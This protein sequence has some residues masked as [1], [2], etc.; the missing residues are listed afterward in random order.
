MLVTRPTEGDDL[1]RIVA[2]AVSGGVDLVQLRDKEAS[3]ESVM[4]LAARLREV[5]GRR[6]VLLVNHPEWRKML[7]VVDGVHLPE[8][9]SGALP[10]PSL[11]DTR[12]PT[13]DT[14]LFGRS[15]H[16][17]EAAT[18]AVEEGADYVVA[19]AIFATKSHP[20]MPP[21]G[22][23][24]LREV[25]ASVNRPV[26]AIGGVT[27][28]NAADCIRAGAAGVAVLSP[29]MDAAD[30]A[31]VAEAYRAVLCRVAMPSG[32]TGSQGTHA[33]HRSEGVGGVSGRAG[34]GVPCS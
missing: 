18:A 28:E 4:A 33:R 27:P 5:I 6:A 13:P 30:P 20:G 8:G 25:C 7:G 2:A 22:L 3:V 14:L 29:L 32:R 23:S 11:P 9:V 10:N 1:I 16:S 12:H 26:F 17:V 34:G 15:V 24:F 21:A 31:A 19:G